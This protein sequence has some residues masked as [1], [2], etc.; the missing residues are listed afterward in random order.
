[1]STQRPRVLFFGAGG[2]DARILLVDSGTNDGGASYEFLARSNPLVPADPA[3]E[4]A[5]FATFLVFTATDT[6]TDLNMSVRLYVNENTPLSRAIVIPASV[7]EIRH[8]FEI[9]WH[10]S[11]SNGGS[12]RV[13]VAPRGYMMVL[14]LESTGVIPAGRIVVDGVESEVEVLGGTLTSEAA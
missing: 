4:L 13:T 14:E 7:G 3:G 10:E 6:T 12:E 11:I 8:Q 1:M 9:S 5:V 2:G